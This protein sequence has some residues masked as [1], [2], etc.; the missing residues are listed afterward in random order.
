MKQS[1]FR[2]INGIVLGSAIA[3]L[4]GSPALAQEKVTYNMSW[5]P[6]GSSSGI[7]VAQERG[8]FRELGLEVAIVR[9]YGGSRTAN[10]LDQGQFEFGYVDP[11]STILNRANGGRIK[12]V[13]AINTRWPAAICWVVGRMQPK[14]LDDLR[15][16]TL[17]GGSASVVHNIVPAW[18]EMNGKQSDLVKLVRMDP[19]VVDTSLIGG[20]IDL[21]ECWKASNRAVLQK[22][23][24]DAGVQVAWME[25][26]DFGLNAYGSGF[27]ASEATIAAKPETVRKFLRG[28]YRGFEFSAAN[29]EQAADVIV[30]VFPASDRNVV[31]AQTR[32]IAE[33]I[34]D[35]EV[36]AQGLGYM[37]ED[38]MRA[39]L[40]FIGK[41]FQLKEPV[42]L[43]D[44][45]T[46]SFLK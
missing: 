2:Q 11:I 34:N 18:L 28:A 35:P 36:R 9:G 33:L 27:A 12:M 38:R 14:T 46:N 20:K 8:F 1:V 13:G 21:A 44:V 26:A 15:G 5:L 40:S 4:A 24:R 39:S 30:K 10:E 45:Y 37:R 29:P 7:I 42:K 22:L 19:A 17:G 25:Y 16:K 31:L 41:A 43:E 23:A 32:E 3:V 6:Q